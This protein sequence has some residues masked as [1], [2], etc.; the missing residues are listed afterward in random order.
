METISKI[1]KAYLYFSSRIIIYK[2]IPVFNISRFSNKI[3]I[4]E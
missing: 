2:V 1:S 3:F 4:G